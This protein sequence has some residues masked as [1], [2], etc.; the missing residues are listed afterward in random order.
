[1][2]R[3]GF[4]DMNG[5]TPFGLRAAAEDN[6]HGGTIMRELDILAQEFEREAAVTRQVLERLPEEHFG[7]KPHEKSW[8]AAGLASHLTNIPGWIAPCLDQPEL[9][10]DPTS[11]SLWMAANRAD[12]LAKFDENVAAGL[13]CLRRQSDAGLGEPW[14]LKLSG[15]SVFTLPKAAVLRGFVFSHLIHHRGQLSV[16]LRLLNAPVPSIYGPS[17]DEGGF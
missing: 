11:R 3:A 4:P 5:R 17:A 1:M 12:L 9:S 2:E 13:T 8:P 7:W 16:Y 15:R 10:L 14:T 6:R